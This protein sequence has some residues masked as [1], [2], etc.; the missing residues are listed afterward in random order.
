MPILQNIFQKAGRKQKLAQTK[1]QA[2]E[3]LTE[4]TKL[5]QPELEKKAETKTRGK[6]AAG[7]AIILEHAHSA[8]GVIA[9]PHISEK[10]VRQNAQHKYVFEI[11]PGVNAHKVKRVVERSY[12]VKV[13]QVHISRVPAKPTHF[14]RLGGVERRNNKAIVTLKAGQQIE[15]LP[16]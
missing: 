15:L 13:E 4:K 6:S 8:Y 2:R 10:S 5:K 11:Y 9:R 1:K 3:A 14:R 16:Q 12:G 7:S